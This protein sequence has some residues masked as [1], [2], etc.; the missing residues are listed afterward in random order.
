ML[1][2]LM[3]STKFPVEGRKKIYYKRTDPLAYV[4]DWIT[5]SYTHTHTY[6]YIYIYILGMH[7]LTG[8]RIRTDQFLLIMR[9]RQPDVF[10]SYIYIYA[11]S[12]CF[13]PKRLTIAFRLYIFIS[14]CVPWESNPQ[15]FALLTQCSEP[16]RNTSFFGLFF[17][18]AQSFANM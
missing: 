7:R 16:H 12:R 2:V 17:R 14:I 4:L 10:L 3:H 11:F 5:I 18:S 9:N 13:Y 6:T 8:Q 15:P 1:L